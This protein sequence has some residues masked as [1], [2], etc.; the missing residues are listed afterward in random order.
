MRHLN[1][2]FGNVATLLFL[3]ALPI[4]ALAQGQSEVAKAR[5]FVSAQ[6]VGLRSQT[7]RARVRTLRNLAFAAYA[8]GDSAKAET[9]AITLQSAVSDLKE[10]APSV[11]LM[12]IHSSN[13]VLGLVALDRGEVERANTYLLA[14]GKLSTGSPHFIVAGPNMLLAKRLL[15]KGQRE[16]VLQYLDL[17]SGFWTD[18]KGKLRDWKRDIESGRSP[19]FGSQVNR[20]YAYW[21][22]VDKSNP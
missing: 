6:E 22:Y 1:K 3:W 2:R 14:S 21:R 16:T 13:T 17:C 10:G 19:D 11:R 18:D 8:A 5:D 7:G 20:V 9:F 4:I 12:A 15:E